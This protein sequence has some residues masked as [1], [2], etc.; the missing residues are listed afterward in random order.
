VTPQAEKARE[1]FESWLVSTAPNDQG[2]WR[3]YCPLHEEPGASGTPSASFNFDK[4]VFECFSSCGGMNLRR[5]A[6]LVNGDRD[7]NVRSISSA[8]SAGGGGKGKPQQRTELPDEDQI[9]AFTDALLN[10]PLRL[11]IMKEKRGFTKETI[12]RFQLGWDGERFTIPVRNVD[13]DLVNVR[14]Y[15]PEA[16][17]PKDKMRS[18]GV[19]L[20]SAELFYPSFLVD[21]DEVIITEGETDCIIGQ[22]YG[23]PTVAHTGGALTFRQEWAQS[24][25]DKTVFICYDLDKAGQ[26]GSM[27]VAN[28]LRRYARAVYILRLEDL[29]EKGADLTDYFVSSGRT[30]DD[31]R[32]FMERFRDA[33]YSVKKKDVVNV[34]AKEVT[35]ETSMSAELA[36]RPVTMTV[37]VAG[38]VQPAYVLPRRITLTCD[39]QAG[40][41]CQACPMMSKG[42]QDQIS[43]AEDD[44]KL[45]EMV[46]AS[47]D[48]VALIIKKEAGIP[49]TCGRV[50]T[51]VYESWNV[52]ELVVVPSVDARGEEQQSPISR[53]IYNVGQFATQVNTS[54]KLVGL[55]VSNPKNGRAAFQAWKCEPVLTNLDQFEVNEDVITRLSMFRPQEGQKPIEKMREIARDLAANV[56]RI[57]GRPELHIAYDAVWHSVMDFHFKGVRLGKGWLELLVMGDTRTGKSEVAQ[58]LCDH[59]QAG[60]LKSCEGATFA[61]LVG[62]AQQMGTSWMVTWGTIPL[63]DRRLVVLDEVSGIKDKGIIDQMSAVRSSGRAQ[64]TKIVGQETSARTRL[65]WISNPPE[66]NSIKEMPGGAIDAIGDLIKNPEDIS[67]FDLAMSAASDDVGSDVI[68][69]TDHAD[70]DHVYDSE[71]SRELV[72]WVWSRKAH[73]IHWADGVENYVLECAES[74]GPTYVP[75]PPLIQAENVRVKLAR[76][77]V[78]VAA[79]LFSATEDGVNVLVEREHVDAAM[80]LLDMLY[81]MRSFGYKHH[82]KKV[83]REREQG[84]N[85]MRDTVKYLR[86]NEDTLM[87]LLQCRSGDFKVRDFCEFAGMTQDEAQVATRWLMDRKMIRRMSRGYIRATPH[88]ITIL[89]R[90]E[91]DM[92]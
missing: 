57:Y 7:D 89:N 44:T 76:I 11:K 87:A 17:N 1:K 56:T 74:F 91:D 34:E 58:R 48:K 79:R 42:L 61:G 69:A 66:G 90:M 63:N 31:F 81:G 40:N 8:P 18:W 9:R 32:E 20:G 33:P 4:G 45:L 46:D 16:K 13:G 41:K 64:I 67:R 10:T 14:R 70:V 26:Q 60:V 83:I 12:E 35:L 22:Q 85:N 2:E 65:I 19:G 82:S 47:S 52:E 75:E 23:L 71:L 77:A 36:G 43:I 39:G 15:N 92:G 55:N 88:L 3:G 5:L 78:A 25:E 54:A 53:S 6:K 86:N 38:K 51:D 30:A 80:E 27:K 73:E 84:K 24:F 21:H 72:N 29:Q 37:S 62:G 49:A 59:Y 68:N 28:M 50:E